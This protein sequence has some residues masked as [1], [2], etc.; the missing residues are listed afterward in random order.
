MTYCRVGI[1]MGRIC[2]G[3]ARPTITT[4]KPGESGNRLVTNLSIWIGGQNLN[5]VGYNIG[6]AHIPETA[7]LTGET[8]QSTLADG[9][10]GVTQSSAKDVRGRIAG[11]MIKKEQTEPPHRQIR[12]GERGE[13]HRG[14]WD[15]L[16]QAPSAFFREREPSVD[17]I[18][19]DFEVGPRHRAQSGLMAT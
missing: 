16:A 12:V 17:E 10:N 14:E 15:L 9:R 11:V 6:D 1:V 7:P 19:C 5:E 13:L 3:F 2:N 4:D 18:I 8:M